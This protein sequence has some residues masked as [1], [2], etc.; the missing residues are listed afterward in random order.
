MSLLSKFGIRAGV[1]PPPPPIVTSG[2]ILHLDASNPLS[3]S[4]SGTTWFDLSGNSRHL[5]L[6]NNIGYTTANGGGLVFN[7]SS[8]YAR[9]TGFNHINV[10]GPFTISFWGSYSTVSTT[11]NIWT[12]TNESGAA[13]QMG[14]RTS[15]QGILWGA[16]GGTWVTYTNPTLNQIRYWTVTLNGSNAQVYINGTLNNST[17]SSPTQTGTAATFYLGSFNTIPSEAFGGTIYQVDM[18]NRVLTAAEVEQNFLATKTRFG[19]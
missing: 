19:L 12:V 1:E 15:G 13:A 17:T 7:G 8:H 16:G 4:G 2:L 6:F 10:Q 9:R 3:Y 14:T 11:R 5:S 18:Y